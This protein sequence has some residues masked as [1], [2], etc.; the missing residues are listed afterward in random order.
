MNKKPSWNF[1]LVCLLVFA[2]L[3]WF[4][5][6]LFVSLGVWKLELRGKSTDNPGIVM[7]TFQFKPFLYLSYTLS[8][9]ELKF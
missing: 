6:M 2:A 1:L 3:C 5:S 9:K 8:I 4:I 7:Q